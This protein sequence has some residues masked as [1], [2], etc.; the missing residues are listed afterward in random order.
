[1]NIIHFWWLVGRARSNNYFR[2]LGSGSKAGSY[3]RLIDWLVFQAH[4]LLYHSTLGVGVIKKRRK[5]RTR[6]VLPTRTRALNM[7]LLQLFALSVSCCVF[8]AW[9]I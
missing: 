5:A 2:E 3:F 6:M 7:Y 9:G 1:L 8:G 4:R